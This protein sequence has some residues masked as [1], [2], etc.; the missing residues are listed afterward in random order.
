MH[1]LSIDNAAWSSRWRERALGDKVLISLGLVMC[2]LWLPPWP[3]S[4]VVST[5]AV[6]LVIGAAGTPWW[7]LLRSMRAPLAFILIGSISVAITVTTEPALSLTMT[8]QSLNR[9]GEVAAHSVAGTLAM[10]LLAMTT[11][12][13]DLLGGLR[14]LRIPDPCIEVAGLIYR[15]VFIL[16]ESLATIRESQAARLGYVT[17]RR[18]FASSAMLT[19]SVLTRSWDRARR[20]EQGLAGRGFETTMR[21]LDQHRPGSPVFRLLSVIGLAGIVAGSLTVGATLS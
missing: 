6:G 10:L 5:A 13:V 18:S 11:P 4:I 16:L 21:T 8:P 9:A 17:W 12:M 19:A 20:L 15:M 7:L 3:G 2:A 1:G 14:R